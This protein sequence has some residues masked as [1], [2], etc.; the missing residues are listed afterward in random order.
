MQ[1]FWQ[2][3]EGFSFRFSGSAPSRM[4]DSRSPKGLQV[5]T[6]QPTTDKQGGLLSRNVDFFLEKT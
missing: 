6:S 1:A 5:L 4:E 3:I 2:P